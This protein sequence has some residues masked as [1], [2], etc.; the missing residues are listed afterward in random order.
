MGCPFPFHLLNVRT[1]FRIVRQTGT[2]LSILVVSRKD[3]YRRYLDEKWE[4]KLLER[5]SSVEPEVWNSFGGPTSPN[6]PEELFL[7]TGQ[8]LASDFTVYHAQDSDDDC[9]ITM[10]ARAEGLDWTRFSNMSDVQIV[11]DPCTRTASTHLV[12]QRQFGRNEVPRLFSIC[13]EVKLSK[14]IR[15]IEPARAGL[16]RKKIRNTFEY[17]HSQT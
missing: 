10:K 4:R 3:L 14:P 16:T 1:Q 11:F 5:F 15:K 17:V 12:Q 9:T 8:V 13:L 7:V 2:S 6:R